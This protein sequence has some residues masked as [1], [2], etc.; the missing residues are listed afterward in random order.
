LLNILWIVLG[1]WMLFSAIR[2]F[3]RRQIFSGVLWLFFVS[4]LFGLLMSGSAEA[5]RTASNLKSSLPA[6]TR[7]VPLARP[8]A[9]VATPIETDGVPHAP[10]PAYRKPHRHDPHATP[11]VTSPGAPAL[12]AL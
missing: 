11:A 9:P 4:L 2:A 12:K 8:P 10:S 5:S 1:V 7:V 6:G 3:A